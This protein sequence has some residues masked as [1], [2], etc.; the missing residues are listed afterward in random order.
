MTAQV[1]TGSGGQRTMPTLYV[2]TVASNVNS[3]YG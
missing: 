3:L 1:V 2:V